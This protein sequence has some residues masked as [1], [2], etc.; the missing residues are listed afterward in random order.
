M[1]LWLCCQYFIFRFTFLPSVIRTVILRTFGASVGSGVLIRRGVRVHIPW[2][3][4]IGDDCWIGEEVWFINHEKITIGSNVCISQRSIICS[5]GHDY[6]SASLEYAHKPV[7][8][9]D[10]AW[11]CLDAKVLPGV[12]IGECSV[13]SAGEIVRKSLPDYS[14]LVGGQVRQIDPPK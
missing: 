7:V 14:M 1:G 11:V 10:G 12:T 4:E 6:R 8:I 13:V 3:L 5:G 2:N 9:K